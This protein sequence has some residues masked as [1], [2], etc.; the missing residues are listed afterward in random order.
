[1]PH[2]RQGGR[3]SSPASMAPSHPQSDL[4]A[5]ARGALH[6]TR[7]AGIGTMD[8]GL[9][10]LDV[11]ITKSS[12]RPTTR[13]GRPCCL[14]CARWRPPSR[15]CC[16]AQSPELSNGSAAVQWAASPASPCPGDHSRTATPAAGHSRA[17]PRQL[18]CSTYQAKGTWILPSIQYT[19][20]SL[21]PCRVN[22]WMG[23]V[24]PPPT[25]LDEGGNGQSDK[26]TTI[27]WWLAKPGPAEAGL[28]H[29]PWTHSR[30]PAVWRISASVWAASFQPGRTT[31]V[32]LGIGRVYPTL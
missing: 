32:A 16:P 1:M 5:L 13:Q 14:H 23:E 9:S 12:R 28:P 18:S 15:R 24:P 22:V 6:A 11:G 25:R 8:M 3:G 19:S 10:I 20:Y 27:T 30:L 17:E 31:T 2:A 29:A 26:L 7:S 21:L 4:T